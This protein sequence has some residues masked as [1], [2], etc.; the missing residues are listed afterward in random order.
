MY[1]SIPF[2]SC[3][4]S[5][6]RFPISCW[7]MRFTSQRQTSSP[8]CLEALRVFTS[9][10]SL[11]TRAQISLS[12]PNYCSKILFFKSMIESLTSL[13]RYPRAW[14]FWN[15]SLTAGSMCSMWDWCTLRLIESLTMVAG[16]WCAVGWTSAAAK[17]LEWNSW[18]WVTGWW[19]W[20][21]VVIFGTHELSTLTEV[22]TLSLPP[23][24]YL[25]GAADFLSVAISELSLT[26]VAPPEV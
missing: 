2:I 10:D 14:S 7:T 6:W 24:N 18:W 11:L 3:A 26:M 21:W 15:C 8:V 5:L 16:T 1:F 25:K 23:D 13:S 20:V 9:W 12:K 17:L 4:R 22:L 19:L